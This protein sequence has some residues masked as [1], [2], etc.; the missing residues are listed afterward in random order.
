MV[1][2]RKKATSKASLIRALRANKIRF[3]NI[4][5][6]KKAGKTTVGIYSVTYKSRYEKRG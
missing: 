6:I 1:T 3:S 2:I 4:K 5:T